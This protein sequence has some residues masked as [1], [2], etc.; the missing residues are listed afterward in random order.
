MCR[1]AR[2]WLTTI[3]TNLWRDRLRHDGRTPDELP[4]EQKEMFSLYQRLAD[5]DPW[6]YS[7]PMHVDFL[8]S[9]T[10]ATARSDSSAW[11]ASSVDRID[12]MRDPV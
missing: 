10:T 6:P 7:D 8:R 3:L 9:S 1:R 12:A 5:E 2:K 4:V 11:T